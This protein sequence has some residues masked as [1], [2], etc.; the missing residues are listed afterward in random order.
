M[1]MS[2]FC[3]RSLFPTPDRSKI[4]GVPNAPEAMMTILRARACLVVG[5]EREIL[6]A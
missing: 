4:D 1:G 3:N 6:G 2:S 5:F